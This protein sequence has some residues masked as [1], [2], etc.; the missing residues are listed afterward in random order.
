MELN[1]LPEK[2]CFSSTEEQIIAHTSIGVIEVNIY[3]HIAL[4]KSKE[5]AG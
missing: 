2:L 1:E 5:K 4:L 3:P